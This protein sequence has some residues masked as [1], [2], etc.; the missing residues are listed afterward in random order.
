V[1]EVINLHLWRGERYL[2]RGL[3]FQIS[4][5][6]ALQL[7]WPNGTGKTSLLRCIAGFV[8]PEEGAVRWNGIAVAKDREAFNRDLAY[9]GH[10]TALKGDL[11]AV[12]NLQYA[13]ALRLPQ[14]TTHIQQTLA[15]M[16]LHE[17]TQNQV[18]RSL[19]AGQ[20]RRVAM[21]RLTL[22][23]AR[24]WLL[25][26]PVAN[27]DMAGQTLMQSV[28]LDHLKQGGMAILATHQ[29]IDLDGAHCRL[30]NTAEVGL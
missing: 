11:T 25:D 1:L 5:G 2:L 3:N 20:K 15:V 21:A 18:V 24:L 19:S 7:L 23:G 12:E 14:S 13:C 9:L 30:W 10:E 8:A 22:W 4:P 17:S 28:L 27:L 26:E 16:G 29:A 6:Q